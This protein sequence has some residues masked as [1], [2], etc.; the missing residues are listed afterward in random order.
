MTKKLYR[1]SSVSR[2]FFSVRDI[3]RAAL[4]ELLDFA[5]LIAFLLWIF[6]VRA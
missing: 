3:P 2:H 4:H 6:G 5:S 1:S